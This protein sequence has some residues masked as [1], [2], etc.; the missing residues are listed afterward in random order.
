MLSLHHDISP[1]Q[2]GRIGPRAVMHAA[3]DQRQHHMW[4]RLSFM[5]HGVRVDTS[6]PPGVSRHT[7]D[8]VHQIWVYKPSELSEQRGDGHLC[9]MVGVHLG[10][11]SWR[12]PCIRLGRLAE[13]RTAVPLVLKRTVPACRGMSY[14]TP[15][16][17]LDLP[18]P[19][20][21]PLSHPP[22]HAVN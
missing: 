3:Q 6:D 15:T 11:S 2:V 1:W 8:F 18:S 9:G 19:Q 5:A 14:A 12:C 16:S 13:L 7:P 4:D 10:P 17:V 22:W 20:P 21:E